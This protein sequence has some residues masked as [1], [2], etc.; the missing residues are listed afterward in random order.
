MKLDELVQTSAAVAGTASRLEK[1]SKLAALL[2]RLDVDEVAIAIG[3]LIGFPR[4]GK[5]GVG[6]A[7][8]S[9]ARERQPAATASLE[10]RDVDE[11]FD[12]VQTTKGK[13][14]ASEKAR[15]VG[16]LFARAAADEQRFLGAL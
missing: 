14:S 10:L 2:K 3:F 5:I 16:E 15:L 4:Q 1:V 13:S 9:A 7:T 11:M 8:V 12:R 6:W